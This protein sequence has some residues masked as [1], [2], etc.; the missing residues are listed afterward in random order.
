MGS[1]PRKI[2]KIELTFFLKNFDKNQNLNLKV[3]STCPVS[4]SLNVS[5]KKYI[6]FIYP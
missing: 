3:A 5:L 4:N 6:N 1:E 2:D